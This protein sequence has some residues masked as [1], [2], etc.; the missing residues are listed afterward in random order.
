MNSVI[1]H[2]PEKKEGIDYQNKSL[3]TG[4][5][6]PAAD[7]SESQLNFNEILIKNSSSTYVMENAV[8]RGTNWGIFKGDLLVVDRSLK[9]YNG[10]VLVANIEGQFTLCKI[11]NNILY[12]VSQDYAQKYDLNSD[13]SL[14]IDI[15]GII[16][17]TIHK[18]I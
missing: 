12:A 8:D 13:M 16:T 14:E 9:P 11:H 15:W 4:F 18:F 10:C 2:F 3:T 17:H 1:T 7:Y 5:P 6:S